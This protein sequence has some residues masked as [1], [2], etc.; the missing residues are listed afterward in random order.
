MQKSQRNSL[1]RQLHEKVILAAKQLRPDEPEQLVDLWA[2]S[3][4]LRKYVG[5]TMQ[6]R[7]T[8]ASHYAH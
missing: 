5:N 2:H 4:K 3:N 6:R 8:W 1:V 7:M